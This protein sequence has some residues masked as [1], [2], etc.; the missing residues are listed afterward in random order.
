MKHR[1]TI[2]FWS[3]SNLNSV[4]CGAIALPPRPPPAHVCVRASPTKAAACRRPPARTPKRAL[5]AHVWRYELD[6]GPSICCTHACHV[7]MHVLFTF[8]S[9]II[10]CSDARQSR[11]LSASSIC[12]CTHVFAR[13]APRT[14]PSDEFSDVD[15][16]ARVSAGEIGDDHNMCMRT[17][18]Q[19]I[20]QS[21]LRKAK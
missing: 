18:N 8:A 11:R 5:A 9:R 16:D 14:R 7:Q 3:V 15:L 2:A 13:G 12:N 20:R 17:V 6:R 21:M 1:K 4:A 19:T 10:A